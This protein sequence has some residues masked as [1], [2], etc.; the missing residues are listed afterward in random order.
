MCDENK[1][2]LSV[3]LWRSRCRPWHASHLP[4][5]AA[6]CCGPSVLLQGNTTYC[7]CG[8]RREN[9]KNKTKPRLAGPHR[10]HSIDIHVHTVTSAA[11]KL[12]CQQNACKHAW[13][14]W[15]KWSPL[16]PHRQT[17]PNHRSTPE[18]KVPLS[19][20][21]GFYLFVFLYLFHTQSV[22]T[23]AYHTFFSFSFFFYSLKGSTVVTRL[24][25][26]KDCALGSL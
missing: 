17:P 15:C 1:E 6:A 23:D 11:S 26:S 24:V 10:A 9:K 19:Q 14:C 13:N 7:L 3:F 16:A 4:V 21:P 5:L 20:I 2:L 25:S 18:N 22:K 12:Q 8:C